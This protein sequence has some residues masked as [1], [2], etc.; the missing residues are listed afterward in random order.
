VEGVPIYKM[1]NK[2]DC[3]NYQGIS[4]INYIQ[5]LSNILLSTL[6][7]YAEEIIGADQC[8]F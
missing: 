6:N 4:F 3:S 7:P 1:G 5:Q 8:R 2:K